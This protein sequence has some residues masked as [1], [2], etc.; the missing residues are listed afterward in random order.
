[1]KFLK[2]GTLQHL[3]LVK[4]SG[5]SYSSQELCLT[6]IF[7]EEMYFEGLAWLFSS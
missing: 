1:M 5:E 4:Y 7:V 2:L 6:N 3:N